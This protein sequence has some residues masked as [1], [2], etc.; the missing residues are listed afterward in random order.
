MCVDIGW[1]GIICSRDA[2]Q[3]VSAPDMVRL[4]QCICTMSALFRRY[5]YGG[6][7]CLAC[8][9]MI[10]C[11]SAC[12]IMLCLSALILLQT[13]FRYMCRRVTVLAACTWPSV[14]FVQPS[15]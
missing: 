9:V 6:H 12:V 8:I 7:I 13:R 15:C 5:A 2:I 3:V 14:G 1:C 11:T 4:A 10:S